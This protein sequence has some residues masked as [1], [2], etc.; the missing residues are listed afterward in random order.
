MSLSFR[1]KAFLLS[2]LLLSTPVFADV[3]SLESDFVA[4]QAL[5]TDKLNNDRHSLTDGSNNVRG[6]YAGSVQSSGQVKAATIGAENMAPDAS[7][8]TRTNEGASCP[9]LVYSGFL[10]ATSSSLVLSIPVGVAYPDGYRVEK[11]SSTAATLTASKWTYYYLLT[12]G[13]FTTNVTTIAASTPSAPANSATLFRASTDATTINTITDLRTTSC[14]AGPFDAI[15]DTT[16]EATLDDILKNGAPI[17]R[18]SQAGRTPQGFKQGLFVS[19]DTASTFKVTAG[20]AYI[21]GKFRSVS[22]DTTVTTA[23]AAPLTG[24]SG[25]D[26]GTVTGGPKRYYVYGVADQDAVKTMS[27]TFSETATPPLGITNASLLGSINTDAGNAFTSRD[28]V[29]VHGISEKELPGGWI[30]FNGAAADFA[31]ELRLVAESY[32]V[33]SITDGGAGVYTVTWDADF[34]RAIYPVFPI[35]KRTAATTLL[36]CMPGTIAAGSAGINCRNQSD[37]LDDANPMNVIAFGDTTR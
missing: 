20:S 8:V 22:T 29:T 28:I 33:S 27:Y 17:R 10:P 25:L 21:N 9:D 26:T 3:V 11:T 35:G 7:P 1:F 34:N 36:S 5:S 2:A 30:S 24:G 14:A 32:N 23:V 15:T 37:V 12:S 18:F 16:G 4:G 13:S 19:W 31:A 6:V